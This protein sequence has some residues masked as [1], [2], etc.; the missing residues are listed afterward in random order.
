MS[1]AKL[2]NELIEST[3][4]TTETE[5]LIAAAKVERAQYILSSIKSIKGIFSKAKA[6]L[7]PYTLKHS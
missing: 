3:S 7:I 1:T 5:K 4:N 6:S 2:V